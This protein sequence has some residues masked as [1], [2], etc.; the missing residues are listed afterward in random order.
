MRCISAMPTKYQ[1]IDC[2]SIPLTDF[3]ILCHKMCSTENHADS[4][5]IVAKDVFMDF[6]AGSFLINRLNQ[7][8]GLYASDPFGNTR[9]VTAIV[10][11][12]IIKT[13]IEDLD[14]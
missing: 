13:L 3:V 2:L 9:H 10:P 14:K 11:D 4:S 1:Q 6:E 5:F 8:S 12:F 7:I